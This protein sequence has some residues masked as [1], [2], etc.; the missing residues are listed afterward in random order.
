MKLTNEQYNEFKEKIASEIVDAVTGEEEVAPMQD[1]ADTL[2]EE[3]VEAIIAAKEREIAERAMQEQAMQE[4]AMQ[5]EAMQE[6]YGDEE[7]LT[8]EEAAQLAELEQ[9]AAATY[10]YALRKIAACEELYAAGEIQKTA[11][12]ELLAENGLLCEDGSLSKEAA[13]QSEEHLL[14]AEKVAASYEDAEEKIA[15]AQDCYNESVI[16]LKAAMEILSDLGYE[17]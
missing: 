4:E 16:E 8:E 14:F 15:A 1:V 9:K 5:G 7:E 2:T 11:S 10:E 3:Q 13:E 17:F 6:E 12:I